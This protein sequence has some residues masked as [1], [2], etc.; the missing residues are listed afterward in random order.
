MSKPTPLFASEAALCAAFAEEV[1]RQGW[2]PYAE[3]SGW[4]LLLVGHG[5][6]VGVEAK[7]RPSLQVLAQCA[8]RMSNKWRAQGPAYAVVLVPH[9]PG[10]FVTVARAIGAEAIAPRLREDWGTGKQRIEWPRLLHRLEHVEALHFEE[11]A[12]VPDVVPDVPAGASSPVR[13]TAWKLLALR[14]VARLLQ[15]RGWVTVHDFRDIGLDSSRWYHHWLL[16][17]GD[18]RPQKW[19]RKPG[20]ALADAQHPTAFLTVLERETENLVRDQR[21]H[22]GNLPLSLNGVAR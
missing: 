8:G 4:D 15:I 21:P 7:I 19:V 11:P 16:P 5:L 12:W 13:L 6:Q 18:D 17:Q 20:V 1:I 14:L 10:D 3:T 2:T 9:A 22:I